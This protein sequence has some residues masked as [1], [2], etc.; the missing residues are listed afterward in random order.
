MSNQTKLLVS[1]IYD[2]L[3]AQDVKTIVSLFDPSVE[4]QSPPTL[5]WSQGTYHGIDGA[6]AY[7]TSALEYL[8]QNAFIVEEVHAEGDWAASIG[9][10]TGRFRATGGEF[11]VRFVHF[12]DFKDGLVV[13]CSGISDTHGIVLGYQAEPVTAGS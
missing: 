5:P 12:W 6:M 8:D 3:E 10:W 1:T 7:F 11:D 13:R 9:R 4:V 2:A